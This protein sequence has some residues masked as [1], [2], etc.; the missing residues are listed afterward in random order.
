MNKTIFFGSILLNIICNFCTL[1]ANE[2]YFCIEEWYI[3]NEIAGEI[4]IQLD[5]DRIRENHIEISIKKIMT[6]FGQMLNFTTEAVYESGK[7][8]FS[9]LD[10]WENVVFGYFTIEGTNNEIIVLFFDCEDFSDFGKNI[11]RLYGE[12]SILTRSTIN[13][14]MPNFILNYISR[15]IINETGN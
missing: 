4:K 6:P 1:S 10:N 9:C 3:G 7:Y 11:A 15:E 14:N 12:T 13:Y 5:I 8:V 2:S